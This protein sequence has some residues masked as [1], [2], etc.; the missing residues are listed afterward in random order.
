MATVKNYIAYC[1]TS[2]EAQIC[3]YYFNWYS[4]R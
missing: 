4:T 3:H 1:L 2:S